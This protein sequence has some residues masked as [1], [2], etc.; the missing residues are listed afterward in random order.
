MATG[1]EI[2]SEPTLDFNFE[3]IDIEDP[4][5]PQRL[6]NLRALGTLLMHPSETM[7]TDLEDFETPA[8]LIERNPATVKSGFLSILHEV[9]DAGDDRFFTFDPETLDAIADAND[10]LLDQK[11][12]ETGEDLLELPDEGIRMLRLK[13]FLPRRLTW[14]KR[15][16]EGPGEGTTPERDIR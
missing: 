13:I 11:V 10:E 14:L 5:T 1:D 15:S 16:G 2:L 7:I 8:E 4:P 12:E 3:S 9:V 6:A